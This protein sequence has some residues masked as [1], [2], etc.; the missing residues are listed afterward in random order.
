MKE[1]AGFFE[2]GPEHIVGPLGE[3]C[4]FCGKEF[5][6]GEIMKVQFIIFHSFVSSLDTH[7]TFFVCPKCVKTRGTVVVNTK[8]PFINK[9]S[10][11]FVEEL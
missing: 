5:E 4:A 3:K 10:G 9:D 11:Y 1:R 7:H 6:E 2:E 8:A